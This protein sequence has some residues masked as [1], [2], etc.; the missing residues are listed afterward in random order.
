VGKVDRSPEIGGD[1]GRNDSSQTEFVQLIKDYDVHVSVD[2]IPINYPNVTSLLKAENQR[3]KSRIKRLEL[4][5]RDEIEM[6]IN[7]LQGKAE[8][9][10]QVKRRLSRL[11]GSLKYPGHQQLDTCSENY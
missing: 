11:K 9:Y 8:T 7:A 10:D 6:M 3:L 2:E 5:I 1:L 4:E